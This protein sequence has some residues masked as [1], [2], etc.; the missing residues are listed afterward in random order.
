MTSV[1]NDNSHITRFS[2]F[3]IMHL[4]LHYVTVFISAEANE[5]SFD[6]D[7]ILT[8]IEQIDSGWWIGTA[9]DGNHGMFPA[10][11]VELV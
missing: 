1:T 3:I 4:L 11:Y 8:N 9:P 5:I 6:P 10:N 2:E 7:D